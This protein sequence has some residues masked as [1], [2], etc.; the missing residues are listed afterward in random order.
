MTLSKYKAIISVCPMGPV[1]FMMHP[2]QPVDDPF[3][4]I[5][6]PVEKLISVSIP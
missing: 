3:H 2:A 4:G 5:Y 1:V 6:P